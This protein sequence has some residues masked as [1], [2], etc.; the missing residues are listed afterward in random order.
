[1]PFIM[2]LKPRHGTWASGADVPTP[3]NAARTPAWQGPDEPGDWQLVTRAFSDGR[4]KIW[5]APTRH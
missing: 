5:W 1:L 2:A 4:T 3:V